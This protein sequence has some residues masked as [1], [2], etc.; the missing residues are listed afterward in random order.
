MAE[1]DRDGDRLGQVDGVELPARHVEVD[2]DRAVAEVED[3]R[4][5]LER[6]AAGRPL[7]AF[8]LARRK[9]ASG[10]IFRNQHREER[11]PAALDRAIPQI[12][13]A[14]AREPSLPQ[15]YFG[16]RRRAGATAVRPMRP[17]S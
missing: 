1:G 3:P 2:P 4:D 15:R 17:R 10:A 9:R 7:E 11:V 16:A 13:W 8:S 5:L 14:A 6:P 12:C